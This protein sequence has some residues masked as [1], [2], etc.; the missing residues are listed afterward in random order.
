MI[1]K[2][3]FQLEGGKISLVDDSTSAS[4][5]TPE[6]AT[7]PAKKTKTPITN[8]K[9]KI[10]VEDGEGAEDQKGE[11]KVKRDVKLDESDA[12]QTNGADGDEELV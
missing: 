4:V 6:K 12:N 7:A 2:L 1:K 5:A 9:R 8:K 10:A 3:G 11:N